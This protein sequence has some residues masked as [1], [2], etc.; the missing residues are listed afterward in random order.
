MRRNR[1][2]EFEGDGAGPTVA[3]LQEFL[4]GC[5]ADAQLRFYSTSNQMDGS[6]WKVVA[7]SD[8]AKAKPAA[9]PFTLNHPPGVR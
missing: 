6:S 5:P 1:V 9:A 3:E 4:H 7:T 2:D 8:P